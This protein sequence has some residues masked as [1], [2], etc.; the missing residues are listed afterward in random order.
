MNKAND[1]KPGCPDQ[2]V[3]YVLLGIEAEVL[4]D[5]AVS[6][7]L[8]EAYLRLSRFWL[9]YAGTSQG[10][11][12][13]CAPTRADMYTQIE[14][15]CPLDN[16]GEDIGGASACLLTDIEMRDGAEFP[17]PENRKE[18]SGFFGVRRN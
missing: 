2:R 3:H 6:P 14:P 5:Q 16:A 4:S 10:G 7:Y 1:H 8:R 18:D 12:K 9:A 11:H 13:F 17:L 15:L